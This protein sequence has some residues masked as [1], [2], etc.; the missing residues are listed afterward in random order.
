MNVVKNGSADRGYKECECHV[1]KSVSTCT[2]YNDFYTTEKHGD[3]LLCES[4][5][6]NYVQEVIGRPKVTP[7]GIGYVEKVERMTKEEAVKIIINQIDFF[8]F[9]LNVA[10]I[11]KYQDCNDCR[12]QDIEF[13]ENKICAEC[14]IENLNKLN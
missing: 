9:P 6:G 5:F 7:M 13:R 4:C 3:N 2:P 12:C 14:W 11:S 1:C 10:E 8:E